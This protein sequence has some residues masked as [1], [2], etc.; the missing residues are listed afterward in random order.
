MASSSAVSPHVI[1]TS[2]DLHM[3]SHKYIILCVKSEE[4]HRIPSCLTFQD[5]ISAHVLAYAYAHAHAHFY[6]HSRIQ[7]ESWRLGVVGLAHFETGS[8]NRQI[9][10]SF[11]EKVQQALE[12]CG[13]VRACNDRGDVLLVGDW[14]VFLVHWKTLTLQLYVLEL[15]VWMAAVCVE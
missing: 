9:F 14:W 3:H 10:D 6:A 11:G 15:R 7:L 8:Y 12:A 13:T 5:W 4:K 1:R 2:S